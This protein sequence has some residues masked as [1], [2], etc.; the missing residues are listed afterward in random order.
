MLN[1]SNATDTNNIWNDTT[2]TSSVFS[3][4]LSNFGSSRSGVAYCFVEK[5]G[6]SKFGTYY[7]NGNDDGTFVYTGFKPAFVMVKASSGV[8]QWQMTDHKRDANVSPNFARLTA[9]SNGAE[10]TNQTWAKIEKFSNGFKMRGTDGVT[11]QNGRTYIYMA[12]GQSLVG[13]NN[14]PCTAR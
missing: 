13:S 6:Y 3:L 4:A 12:F 10:A 8:D 11:N 1:L 2:P 9:D 14:I 7:G 5:T